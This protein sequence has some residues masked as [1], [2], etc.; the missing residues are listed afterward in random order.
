MFELDL[1]QFVDKPTRQNNELNLIL[2]NRDASIINVECNEPI[3][4]HCI[5]C[6][7]VVLPKAL[8]GCDHK[9]VKNFKDDD[10]ESFNF[11][12]QNVNWF[13]VF[14]ECHDVQ[15]RWAVFSNVINAGIE[16]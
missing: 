10:Y 7:D 3:S 5:V 6:A 4:D 2:F 8:S 12:L 16:L 13:E 1:Y 11:H 15:S 9:I 14:N